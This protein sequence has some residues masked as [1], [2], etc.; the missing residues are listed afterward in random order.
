[1]PGNYKK[2]SGIDAPE[3]VIKAKTFTQNIN[4][5]DLKD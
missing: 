2:I 1:M 4:F 3:V 5:E